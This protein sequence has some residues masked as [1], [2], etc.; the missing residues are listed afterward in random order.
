MSLGG[1]G[2]DVGGLNVL[3]SRESRLEAASG[4][5]WQSGD[6]VV[7]V[8]ARPFPFTKNWN[9]PKKVLARLYDDAAVQSEYYRPIDGAIPIC[10]A[11]C[12]SYWWLVVSGK[13]L[14]RVWHDRRADQL[15]WTSSLSTFAEWY[16]DGLEA[17]LSDAPDEPR[18][19]EAHSA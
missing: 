6:G 18:R 16:L 7:G 13:E 12:G 15:G 19:W 10:D 5:R 11:G 1:F 17:A 2:P 4:D 9:L 8:L 3:G 14:G